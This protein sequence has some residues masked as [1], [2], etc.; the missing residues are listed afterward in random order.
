MDRF[1]GKDRP[2]RDLEG[3]AALG[4]RAIVQGIREGGGTT[5]PEVEEPGGTQHKAGGHC[6]VTNIH[7][8]LQA[9]CCGQPVPREVRA[10]DSVLEMG[11]EGW[12]GFD[13]PREGLP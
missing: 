3:H 4:P 8:S 9:V 5:V 7:K 1:R 11:H 12:R 13:Q 6:H 2:N 10:G